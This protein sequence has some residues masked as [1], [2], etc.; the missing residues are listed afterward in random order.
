MNL[1]NPTNDEKSRRVAEKLG[2]W[3][4][5]QWCLD[6]NCHH[7]AAKH[8]R[9]KKLFFP[10]RV[11]HYTPPPDLT[12]P[13]GADMLKTALLK[14]GYKLDQWEAP[15]GVHFS[16]LRESKLPSTLDEALLPENREQ[17]RVAVH[18]DWKRAQLD[19][20]Y[21]LLVENPI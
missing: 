21:K 3:K 15:A 1:L 17:F 8:E 6:L 4:I 2:L 9:P 11:N 19:A 18:P 7:E 14:A 12:T 10:T 13:E 20:T 16:I 5:G